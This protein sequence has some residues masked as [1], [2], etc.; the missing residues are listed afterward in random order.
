MISLSKLLSTKLEK[1]KMIN[2]F[3]KGR[4]LS[5]FMRHPPL[6]CPLQAVE[7]IQETDCPPKSSFV[8]SESA[9]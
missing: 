4:P 2:H 8:L 5:E 6:D 9:P 7:N 1:L 3:K